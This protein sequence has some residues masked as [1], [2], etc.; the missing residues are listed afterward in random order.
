M[1]TGDWSTHNVLQPDLV[2]V[3][4]SLSGDIGGGRGRHDCGGGL[5]DLREGRLAGGGQL[6]DGGTSRGQ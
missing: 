2:E 1:P 5:H 6:T 4:E 3:I